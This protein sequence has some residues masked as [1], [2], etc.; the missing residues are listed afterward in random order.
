MS[1][2]LTKA[3]LPMNIQNGCTVKAACFPV[4]CVFLRIRIRTECSE[5]VNSF[6]NAC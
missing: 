1:A 2:K 6:I 4:M 5:H 3:G